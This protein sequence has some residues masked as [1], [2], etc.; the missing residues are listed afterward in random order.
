MAESVLTAGVE[1][2]I[3]ATEAAEI[4]GLAPQTLAIWRMMGKNLPFT[5]RGKFI[6]YRLSDVMA[7]LEG[8]MTPATADAGHR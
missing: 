3:N 4:V 5:R 2:W 1:R 7:F 8:G 6:R